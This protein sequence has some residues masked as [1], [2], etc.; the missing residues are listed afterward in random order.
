MTDEDRTPKAE[1]AEPEEKLVPLRDALSEDQEEVNPSTRKLIPLADLKTV[2]PDPKKRGKFVRKLVEKTRRDFVQKWTAEHT[3]DTRILACLGNQLTKLKGLIEDPEEKEVSW[4]NP[5][6]ETRYYVKLQGKKLKGEPRAR[7]GEDGTKL[8]PLVIPPVNYEELTSEQ[9]VDIVLGTGVLQAEIELFQLLTRH[10]AYIKRGDTVTYLIPGNKYGDLGDKLTLDL[11]EAREG[12]GTPAEKRARHA[13]LM[14]KFFRPFTLWL[15]RWGE[16]ENGEEYPYEDD[17]ARACFSHHP[18][19]RIKGTEDA[20][21]RDF[22]VSLVLEVHPLVIEL[23]EEGNVSRAW[24]PVVAGLSFWPESAIPEYRLIDPSRWPAGDREELWDTIFKSLH[25]IVGDEKTAEE[26][27]GEPIELR[28][29]A[30]DST[31]LPPVETTIDATSEK[32]ETLQTF[33]NKTEGTFEAVRDFFEENV[34]GGMDAAIAGVRAVSGPLTFPLALPSYARMSNEAEEIIKHV[35]RVR[36]PSKWSTLPRWEQLVQNEIRERLENEGERA[37]ENIREKT[38]DPEERGPL[39]KRRHKAGGGEEVILT[40]EAE[41]SL[42]EKYGLGHGYIA[43]ND[44]GQEYLVRIFQTANRGLLE[45]GLSWAGLA[46][47][48]VKEWRER[49]QKALED[50]RRHLQEQE[51]F[52]FADLADEERNRVDRLMEQARI[53]DDGR[54][55]MEMVLGQVSAQQRNPVEIPAEALRVLL[56]PSSAR[57]RN[58]SSQWRRRVDGILSALHAM[59]F[60]YRTHGSESAKGY[61]SFIG[62]WDYIGRG[63]GSHGDGVYVLDVQPGFLGCLRLFESTKTRLRSG[64]E[65]LYLDFRKDLSKDEKGELRGQGGYLT[66]DA[67]R[68]FY[69]AAAGFTSSQENLVRWVDHELTKKKDSARRENKGRQVRPNAAEANSPR[70]YDHVF[71]PLL[72]EDRGY[73]G[74]LGHFNKNPEAGFTL[75]GTGSR[76]SRHTAGIMAEI[77]YLLPS[78]PWSMRKDDILKNVLGDLKAVVVEY[79]GG[80]VAGRLGNEWLPL[81]RFRELDEKTLCHKLKVLCFVPEDYRSKHRAN[82]EEATGY[83]VTEDPKEAEQAAWEVMPEEDTTSNEDDL[84]PGTFPSVENSFRGLPLRERLREIR[85]RRKLSVKQAGEVFGVSG[86]TVSLWENGKKPIPPASSPLLLRWIEEGTAPTAEE[87]AARRRRE[88]PVTL[89]H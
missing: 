46:G 79:F 13:R 73:Y 55:V 7:W 19:F 12:G 49:L 16:G 18:E 43:R 11:A 63:R 80:V 31:P 20:S 84:T 85:N 4:E 3:E 86:K 75:A 35:H 42:R 26:A 57:R 2:I 45:I 37:F 33:T 83:R 78:G 1:T 39:L 34:P 48:L 47:P 69:N 59:T 72:P 9:A 21:G 65:A 32:T 38:R 64:R 24:Y 74:T 6:V 5:W 66:F 22:E 77:G 36:L 88:A 56:W 62:E 60:Y 28:E 44:L 87:L 52:L 29:S 68:A 27:A 17:L 50:A 8:H 89:S 71:C 51:P 67:G 23:N 54:R 61:G 41:R 25:V 53:W 30:P 82:F 70:I 81:D 58:Y 40:R 14:E 76:L 10:L 15:G